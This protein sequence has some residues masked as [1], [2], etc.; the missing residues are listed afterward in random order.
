MELP[1]TTH[2]FD[3][4][5]S[6]PADSAPAADGL[7]GYCAKCKANRQM[8][9]VQIVTMQTGQKA[10]KGICPVCGTTLTKFLP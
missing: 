1:D 9:Q 4:R 2:S 8:T 6:T 3:N 5:T 10:A 7:Q